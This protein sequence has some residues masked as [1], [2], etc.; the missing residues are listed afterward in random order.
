MEKQK[1]NTWLKISA[2]L[3]IL[4]ILFTYLAYQSNK[5][6]KEMHC[7]F[8]KI[9]SQGNAIYPEECSNPKNIDTSKNWDALSMRIFAIFFGVLSLIFFYLGRRKMKNG[10]RQTRITKGKK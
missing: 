2:F 10:S 5:D 1:T 7:K 4:V 6:Y 9:D 3:F 8:P